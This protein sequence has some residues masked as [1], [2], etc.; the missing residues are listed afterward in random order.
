MGPV[1]G[2]DLGQFNASATRGSMSRSAS[3]ARNQQTG[4]R[5]RRQ[6]HHAGDKPVDEVGEA[7]AIGDMA[8][9]IHESVVSADESRDVRGREDAEIAGVERDLSTL[10]HAA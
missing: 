3:P 8:G 5:R 9:A 1:G 10:N 7:L 4:L 6:R 2:L